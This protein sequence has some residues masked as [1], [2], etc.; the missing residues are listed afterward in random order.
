[1]NEP[2]E[3]LVKF[4]KTVC[5]TPERWT[6]EE[7]ARW[8]CGIG[9]PPVGQSEQ[10][11]VWIWTGIDGADE[12]DT[13]RTRFAERLGEC[14]DKL[15]ELLMSESPEIL[16]GRE[17]S[18]GGAVANL[19]SLM[20]LLK[21]P[22]LLGPMVRQFVARLPAAAWLNHPNL[23]P[24]RQRLLSA[25]IFNQDSEVYLPSWK[26]IAA[27]KAG[28]TVF[29][30]GYPG[31]GVE[32]LLSAPKPVK[33]RLDDIGAAIAEVSKLGHTK[34]CREKMVQ[35]LA[36]VQE[37]F[38][39]VIPNGEAEYVYGDKIDEKLIWTADQY[40]WPD[41]VVSALPE[42]FVV[43]VEPS[44]NKTGA[45]TQKAYVWAPTYEAFDGF[46][47]LGETLEDRICNGE[48]ILISRASIEAVALLGTIAKATDPL[49]LANPLEGR[50]AK[51]EIVSQAIYRSS[52]RGSALWDAAESLAERVL[53][54][55]TSPQKAPRERSEPEF[56][57]VEI[58][59]AIGD[60]MAGKAPRDS[61]KVIGITAG[62]LHR[63]FPSRVPGYLDGVR[64]CS[65]VMAE[66]A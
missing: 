49:R 31:D 59:N 12:R 26:M 63:Q 27:G 16:R 11:Y 41:W 19:W 38:R 56:R 21:Q 54:S 34:E 32:G 43:S 37:Q 9:L 23:E 10:P 60:A 58:S 50:E 8:M 65:A 17:P 3:W 6:A 44:V 33:K 30:A 24:I 4:V 18:P 46:E 5:T 52:K 40:Q 22:T 20:T 25:A 64:T 7:V 53:G 66:C 62:I 14:G 57:Q 48:A 55:G 35:W 51:D 47:L 1:M 45:A 42:M 39:S 61:I 13:W 2:L 28:E 36:R 29:R 15:Y